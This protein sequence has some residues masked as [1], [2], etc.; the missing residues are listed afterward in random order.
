MRFVDYRLLETITTRF[1]ISFKVHGIEIGLESEGESV[2]FCCVQ[3][4]TKHF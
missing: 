2:F 1:I 3:H 4:V